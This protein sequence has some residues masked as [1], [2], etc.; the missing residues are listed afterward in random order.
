MKYC[1]QCGSQLEDRTNFCPYCGAKCENIAQ[2]PQQNQNNSY[3]DNY[4]NNYN[5]NNYNNGY[6]APQ[7]GY[8]QYNN[9]YNTPNNPNG[10]QDTDSVAG[11]ACLAFC[12]PI[13]GIIIYCIWANTRPKNAKT[14]L[15][16]AVVSFVLGIIFYIIS[17]ILGLST[18]D[19]GT[20]Y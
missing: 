9:Q 14:V 16:A 20:G 19:Y 4:N 12:F 10:T 11:W 7:Q 18:A 2:Q 15:T 13:V 5:N 3:N 6:N 17:F 8:N 1:Q